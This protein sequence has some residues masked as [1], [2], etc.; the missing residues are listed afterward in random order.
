MD[1]AI[2]IINTHTHTYNH[3]Y[4]YTP[5]GVTWRSRGLQS[6]PEVE[7]IDRSGT[8]WPW[9]AFGYGRVTISS[10]PQ[11]DEAGWRKI[12]LKSFWMSV[13]FLLS[14]PSNYPWNGLL[15]QAAASISHLS[16]IFTPYLVQ[17]EKGRKLDCTHTSFARSDHGP[18]LT[19]V[20]DSGSFFG[21]HLVQP[22]NI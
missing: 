17:A 4:T 14:E 18:H 21:D 10:K 8:S 5:F 16:T 6:F 15:S 7:R 1:L 3:I 11:W 9:V 20:L 13:A 19:S 22:T 2:I 12:I